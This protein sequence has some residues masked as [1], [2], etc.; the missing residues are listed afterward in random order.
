MSMPCE[1]PA[2]D[3]PRKS[4]LR[5]AAGPPRFAAAALPAVEMTGAQLRTM[6]ISEF[7]H[8]HRAS[9][10]ALHAAGA[11]VYDCRHAD[12]VRHRRPAAG[13]ARV[14]C[15][16]QAAGPPLKGALP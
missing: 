4:P 3:R 15:G 5:V 2:A 16:G 6:M 14:C 12:H 11:T 1:K 9:Q 8:W 7:G 13:P 10:A